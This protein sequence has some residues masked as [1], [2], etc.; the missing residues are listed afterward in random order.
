MDFDRRQ[1]TCPQG[2]VSAGWH[3]P[4]PTSSPTAAPLIVAR[5]T[6]SQCRPCPARTQCTS[7]ADSARTVGF[8]PRELRDLQLRVQAE[9][10]TPEWKARYAV[11][12]GV[13]GTVN[14]FAH[15]HGMRRCRYR[16]LGKV[17]VQH[18]FDGHSR[19]HRAPQRTATSRG[20]PHTPPTDC[21]PELPRP[22]R[23]PS[24]E[25]LAKPGQ[26]TP[27][28]PRSPTESSSMPGTG[29]SGCRSAVLHPIAVEQPSELRAEPRPQLH[30]AAREEL[31]NCLTR[32]GRVSHETNLLR[33]AGGSR[34][35]PS[36]R[37]PGRGRVQKPG[38]EL[39]NRNLAGASLSL[40]H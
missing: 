22:A 34:R 6:K 29:T 26:L 17:H 3:D 7:T 35:Q 21:L 11:R 18:V 9:Q 39:V 36:G 8:P 15:G 23:D 16:G 33:W 37:G 32:G 30:R 38:G 27:P 4:Y 24:P 2:Q 20:S 14:E 12:S 28:T 13:E 5:F 10:Q 40:N 1:V 25:V 31:A 19:Q